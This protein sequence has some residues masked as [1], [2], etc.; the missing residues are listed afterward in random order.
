MWSVVDRNVVMWRISVHMSYYAYG[1]SQQMAIIPHTLATLLILRPD[2]PLDPTKR[3][4]LLQW[5]ASNAMSLQPSEVD[6]ASGHL[7]SWEV[8][9]SSTR[10]VNGCVH[11]GA[12][13]DATVMSIIP[14]FVRDQTPLLQ[15]KHYIE[16]PYYVKVY[17]FAIQSCVKSGQLSRYSDSQ[18]SGLSGVRNP[19]GAPPNRIHSGSWGSFP[20]VKRPGRG[21]DHPSSSTS[22]V[23][24]RI[25]LYLHSPCEP[26][27]QVMEWTLTEPFTYQLRQGVIQP[28]VDSYRMCMWQS[29]Q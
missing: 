4:G 10:G 17:R 19:M 11:T 9:R 12:G 7:H 15:Y 28:A 3:A 8:A 22:D 13:L 21:F 1:F 16:L 26:S 14:V 27:W 20:E 2:L 5:H 25:V 29:F 18:Q 23:K 6:G 24:E